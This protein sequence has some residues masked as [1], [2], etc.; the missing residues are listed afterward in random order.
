[1]FASGWWRHGPAYDVCS[2]FLEAISC[3][4]LGPSLCLSCVYFCWVPLDSLVLVSLEKPMV[5]LKHSGFGR[6]SE[7][8]QPIPM[9]FTL[10]LNAHA[11]GLYID[12]TL[13]H[14]SST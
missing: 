4:M 9:S 7:M 2:N 11:P 3:F 13:I 5:R 12:L 14:R 10:M 8:N 6:G 1:M